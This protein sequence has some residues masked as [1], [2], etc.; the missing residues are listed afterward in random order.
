MQRLRRWLAAVGLLAGAGLSAA[1]A[2]NLELTVVPAWRGWSRPDRITE[3]DI[4]LATD[5]RT[6]ATL[7]WRAG[8]QVQQVAL[9]LQ[10]ARPQRL[11]LSVPASDAM[12]LR[13]VTPGGQTLSREVALARSESPLLALA[14]SSSGPAAL[15]GFHAVSVAAADLPRQAA[16]HAGIDA[17]AIDAPTLAALDA[18]QLAALLGHASACGRIV[19][20]QQDERVQRLLQSAAGCG[21]QALMQAADLADAM[22]RLEASLDRPLA[23]PQVPA[24]LGDAAPRPDRVVWQRAALILAIGLGAIALALLFTHAL[25]ALLALCAVAALAGPLAMRLWPAPA[26]MLIWSEAVS[27]DAQARFHARQQLT[28]VARADARLPIPA[29]LASS[30]RACRPAQ[31]VHWAIEPRSGQPVDAAFPSRLFGQ[32]ALCY[33]GSFPIQRAIAVAGEPGADPQVRNG[34]AMAWPAGQLLWD[35]QVVDLPPM[36]AGASATLQ[37][38][39]RRPPRDAL[40]R[41][42]LARAGTGGTGAL[43]ELDLSGVASLPEGARGWLVMTAAR[44]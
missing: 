35:S 44:P 26:Q 24:D 39:A 34:A 30:V 23:A 18:Q 6:A 2:P 29:Q 21:G 38:A 11:T 32:M 41:A 28:G 3:L 7:Q 13:L 12:T 15:G 19:V 36:G 4:R 43:W 8:A 40:E 14:L 37:V 25:P 42:A 16:A 17:L 33:E 10:P 20:V 31:P 5:T 9:D 22:Q 27:G 1:A